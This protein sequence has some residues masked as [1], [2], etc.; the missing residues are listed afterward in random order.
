MKLTNRLNLPQAIVNAISNDGYSRGECDLSVTQLIAPPRKVELQRRHDDEIVEDV[1]DRIW[2]LVGKAVHGILEAAQTDDLAEE[3]LFM[4]ALGWKVSG[5]FD[6]LA[7][8]QAAADLWKISDY[9]VTSVWSVIFA[10]TKSEW[11]QQLNC[12]AHLLRLH[13]FPVGE[14]EIV[15]ICRDWQKSKALADRDY[16]QCQ[17]SVIPIRLWSHDEAQSF[18]EERVRLHQ[19]TRDASKLPECTS[20]ERWERPTRWAFMKQGAKRATKLFD[21]QEEAEA[22]LK[23]GYRIERRD[24]ESVRCKSYCN[25]N[26]WCDQCPELTAAPEAQ[27]AAA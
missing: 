13:S 5:A 12:Y 3:R 7:M 27:E 16:P 24:G 4:D 19:Q 14:L 20:D 8:I 2:I 11:E 10:E 17:V 21:T 1:S 25:V 18:I 15:A 9:K 26:R 23:P 6:N 22:A